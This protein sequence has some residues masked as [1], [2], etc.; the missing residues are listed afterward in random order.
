MRWFRN[1]H[2][3]C[4]ALDKI[5]YDGAMWEAVSKLLGLPGGE[6]EIFQS[7]ALLKLAG[8]GREKP[9]HQDQV[10]ALWMLYHGGDIGHH[11]W[12]FSLYLI[13]AHLFPQIATCSLCLE[14][15]VHQPLP[16]WQYGECD[17]CVFIRISLWVLGIL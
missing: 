6:L 16:T 9:W 5:V 8:V 12:F 11:V 7:I 1:F 4:D 13:H 3:H 10:R 15:F 17:Y 14:L 2:G